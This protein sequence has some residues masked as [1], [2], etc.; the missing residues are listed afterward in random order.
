MTDHRSHYRRLDLDL[1]DPS[2]EIAPLA[3]HEAG[4]GVILRHQGALVGFVLRSRDALPPGS[5]TPA[6]LMDDTVRTA[7]AAQTLRRERGRPSGPPRALS[8]AICTK[9]GA[10]RVARLLDSLLPLREEVPF[11]VLIIDNGPSDDSTCR[12]AAARDGVRYIVEPLTGLD[13]AR[14]RAVQEATGEVLCFLDDDVTVDAGWARAMSDAWTANPEAGAI[15]GLVLPLELETEAQ[16]LF[17]RG[18]G[19]RRGFLPL[20]YGDTNF[21]D[22]V[23]PA[24]AGKFGAGA[25]MS[26][27]LALVRKLGGFDEALD[28]GRPLPGGG[29][30]DIFY[31]VLRA[32]RPLVYEPQAAVFHEHRRDLSVLKRQYRSWGLGLMAFITKTY[33]ADPAARPALRRLV[34]WW[35]LWMTA[36]FVRRR[37]GREPIP[38]DML[39]AE[40][41][42]GVK[43]LFGEYRRS[44]RRSD[45]IRRGAT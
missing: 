7:M 17:E 27:D 34:L 36:R 42:G 11:E 16:V 8:I 45:R 25:N 1:S 41:S 28:T 3:P 39:R 43:G 13:F 21:A 38:A 6:A 29:D 35:F 37:K 44:V 33:A 5:L 15:T 40:L 4:I 31:R 2:T 22:P 19:F 10:L 12:V 9:D 20:R 24:G 32:G 18:G 23:H 14:N 30:L 26:V